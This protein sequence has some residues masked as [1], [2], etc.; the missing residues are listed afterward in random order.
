MRGNRPGGNRPRANRCQALICAPQLFFLL[1]SFQVAK[2]AKAPVV[3]VGQ[4]GVGGAIDAFSLNASYFASGGCPVLGAVFNRGALEGFYE[5][6]A[7][8]GAIESWFEGTGR[9]EEVFGVVPELAALAGA[10]EAVGGLS[11]AEVIREGGSE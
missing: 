10:R 6:G 8:K 5:W 1:S 3:L 9:R 11:A 7:C 2:A 4:C